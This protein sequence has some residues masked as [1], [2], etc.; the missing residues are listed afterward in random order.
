MTISQGCDAVGPAALAAQVDSLLS[1]SVTRRL[2]ESFIRDYPPTP[3][4]QTCVFGAPTVRMTMLNAGSL[5]PL[6]TYDPTH[7]YANSQR[8][9]FG[10]T[11]LLA[12]GSGT[13]VRYVL[14]AALNRARIADTWDRKIERSQ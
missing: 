6:L 3:Q 4:T 11:D 13:L 10:R 14:V 9:L 12:G 2:I 8:S 1:P 5:R 7:K